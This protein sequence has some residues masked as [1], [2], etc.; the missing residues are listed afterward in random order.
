MTVGSTEQTDPDLVNGERL[1]WAG[2]CASCH[3][4]KNA[5]GDELLLLGGGHR[6]DTPFG[7]F[8]TPNI[9]PNSENGLGEWTSKQF[10]DAM[11]SGTSPDGNHY[12]PSFP[13]TSYNKMSQSDLLDLFPILLLGISSKNINI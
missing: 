10:V 7:T 4:D 13:Y 5:E 6:L 1:F 12:Y 8:V 2:G 9:S 3:A 11:V